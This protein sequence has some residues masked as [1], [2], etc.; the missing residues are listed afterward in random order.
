MGATSTSCTCSSPDDE[1]G[2]EGARRQ[3]SPRCPWPSAPMCAIK[4]LLRP[5]PSWTAPIPDRGDGAVSRETPALVRNGPKAHGPAGLA[6]EVHRPVGGRAPLPNVVPN[7][8]RTSCPNVRQHNSLKSGDFPNMPNMPNVQRGLACARAGA[9][10]ARAH[11]P[12]WCSKVRH[13]RHRSGAVTAS[14]WNR[15]ANPAPPSA[16]RQDLNVRHHFQRPPAPSPGL[17]PPPALRP[18][19]SRPGSPSAG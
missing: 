10:T 6:P 17:P 2:G 9:H 4:P 1:G 11:D 14:G 12:A 16:E 7:V 3:A 13:V 5:F 15:K 19:P 8:C 18:A